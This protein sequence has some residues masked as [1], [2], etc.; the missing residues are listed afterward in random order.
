M[1]KKWARQAGDPNWQSYGAST[2]RKTFGYQNY[3]LGYPLSHISERM[4]HDSERTTRRYCGIGEETSRRIV[5]AEF[6]KPRKT[7]S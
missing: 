1:V 2:L 4:G 5:V 3:M 7:S 6:G